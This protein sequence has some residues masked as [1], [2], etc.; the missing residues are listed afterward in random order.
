ML[1][2]TLIYI[3]VTFAKPGLLITGRRKYGLTNGLA[4]CSPQQER[5]T[6]GGHQHKHTF[7][8]VSFYLSSMKAAMICRNIQDDNAPIHAAEIAQSGFHELKD[9]VKH[10]L[11]PTQ[12]PELNITK[13]FWTVLKHLI[14]N[15]YPPP[16]SVSEFSQYLQEK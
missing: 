4:L 9:E 1:V 6:F 5:C 16:A 10:L 3:D 11:L 14:L 13:P 7:V 12:S 8:N 2:P 15:R